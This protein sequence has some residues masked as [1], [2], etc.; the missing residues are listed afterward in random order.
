MATTPVFSK[1]MDAGKSSLL[2]LPGEIRNHIYAALFVLDGPLRI[3]TNEFDSADDYDF[4]NRD[5]YRSDRKDSDDRAYFRSSE[6]KSPKPVST[7]VSG[8]AI[9]RTCQQ[10]YREATGFLYAQNTIMS[11]ERPGSYSSDAAVRIASSWFTKIGRQASRVRT[12]SI[13]VNFI[14]RE[15]DVLPILRHRWSLG[16]DLVITFVSE[17]TPLVIDAAQLDKTFALLA[18]D[19]T[20]NLKRFARF[21]RLMNRIAVSG[22]GMEGEAGFFPPPNTEKL[23]YRGIR[24]NF[25]LEGDS[26]KSDEAETRRPHLLDFISNERDDYVLDRIG[27]RN[28]QIGKALLNSIAPRSQECTYDLL[29]GV[30]TPTLTGILRTNKQMRTRLVYEVRRGTF[31]AFATAREPKASFNSELSNLKAWDLNEEGRHDAW[32]DKAIPLAP[33][34]IHLRFE[35][36]GVAHCAETSFDATAVV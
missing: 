27:H 36:Q 19:K 31:R 17:S 7:C 16:S 8:V 28:E 15:I 18:A 34:I 32:E 35:L 2:T 29:N 12:L 22:S 26:L 10:T 13:S 25:T 9:L 11:C 5:F 4:N 30:M 3:T 14:W 24:F 20:L 23:D 6:P 1:P 21:P 33:H